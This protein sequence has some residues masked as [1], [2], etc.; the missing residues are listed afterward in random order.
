MRMPMT[1]VSEFHIGA[2]V[3]RV[4]QALTHLE[5]WPGWWRHVRS[6]EMREA[7]DANGVGAVHRLRWGSRLPYGFTLD[8]RT[9]AIAERRVLIGEATGELRGQGRWDLT[10]TAQGTRL[11]YSWSVRLDKPWMHRLA[12]LLAPVFAWNH[13]AVMRD[14]ARGLAS[15]L[16]APFLGYMDRAPSAAIAPRIHRNTPG[17]SEPS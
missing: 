5:D 4:W 7:G 2:P 10:P 9:I 13:H 16:G 15:Y 14:G 8:V 11:R 17:P 3:S 1:L 6:V 12:P